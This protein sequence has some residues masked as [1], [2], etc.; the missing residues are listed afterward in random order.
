MT[1]EYVQF[2]SDNVYF[3]SGVLIYW[4]YSNDGSLGCHTFSYLQF[5]LIMYTRY[6]QKDLYSLKRA[7]GC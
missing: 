6:S 1:S 2:L 7:D 3:C 5:F 4:W